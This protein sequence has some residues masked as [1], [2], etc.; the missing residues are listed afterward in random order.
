MFS[1]LHCADLHL[2]GSFASSQL[3]PAVGRGRRLGLREALGRILALARE[4][5]VDAV[6]VGG[7]LYEQAYAMPDTAQFL[8]QHF[9]D[10]APIR[11]YIAPGESDPYAEDS[12]YALTHWPENVGIF[13]AGQLSPVELAPGIHLWG[14][15]CPPEPGYDRLDDV[16]GDRPG[17]NLLLLHAAR[18]RQARPAGQGLFCLDDLSLREAGFD[19]ALLGHHHDGQIWQAGGV[20]CIYPGSPEPLAPAEADGDHQVVLLT[21]EDGE[22]T[23]ERIPIDR[24][25]GQERL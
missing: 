24:R 5:Q 16:R 9:A 8:R 17:V 18:T 14:A 7:D 15:A 19:L 21:I 12:L 22:F 20:Q 23:T 25:T 10:L 13:S 4:K 2:E 3:P 11:V 1:I 6:T